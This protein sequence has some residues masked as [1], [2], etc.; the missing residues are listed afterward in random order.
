MWAKVSSQPRSTAMANARLNVAKDCTMSKEQ[1]TARELEAMIEVEF[2]DP[3]LNVSVHPDPTLGWDA[4]R[5]HWGSIETDAIKRLDQIAER[6][7]AQYDLK[8]D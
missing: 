1:K 3:R 7:R 4:D 2:N 8:E 6:L 5:T